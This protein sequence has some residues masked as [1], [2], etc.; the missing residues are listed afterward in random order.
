MTEADTA[1]KLKHNWTLAELETYLEQLKARL[2]EF[3]HTLKKIPPD[4]HHQVH[5][6]ILDN[7]IKECEQ[8]IEEVKQ[9]F[10]T[11]K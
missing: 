4:P 5:Q 7:I 8:K 1:C 11:D 3:T 2:I 9:E 10:Y 6:S